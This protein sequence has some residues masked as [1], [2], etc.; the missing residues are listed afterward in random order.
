MALYIVYSYVC[1]FEVRYWNQM[2]KMDGTAY[3]FTDDLS[4]FGCMSNGYYYFQC[5]YSLKSGGGG[6]LTSQKKTTSEIRT[7]YI[8]CSD[9]RKRRNTHT[10]THIHT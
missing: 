2:W 10:H 9:M 8:Y 6:G 1:I 5:V 7:K 4:Q 3:F